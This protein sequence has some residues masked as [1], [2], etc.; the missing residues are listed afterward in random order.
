MT[1]DQ[2]KAAANRV[3]EGLNNNKWDLVADVISAANFAR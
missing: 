2:N 1:T 3:I